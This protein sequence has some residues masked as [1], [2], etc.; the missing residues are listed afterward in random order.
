[1]VAFDSQ[2]LTVFLTM[3]LVV[4]VA[5]TVYA[6]S[7]VA[8]VVATARRTRLARG[9]SVRTYYGRVALHH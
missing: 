9:E 6:T 8:Q 5:S 7:V 2:T 3:L 4:A 1:M